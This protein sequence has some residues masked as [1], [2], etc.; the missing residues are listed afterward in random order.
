MREP[1]NNG[2]NRTSILCDMTAA[3]SSLICVLGK[4]GTSLW[5]PDDHGKLR[6]MSRPKKMKTAIWIG[7]KQW[8]S[9]KALADRLDRTA[10]QLVREAFDLLIKKYGAK[11][12]YRCH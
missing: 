5:Q 1:R 8:A 6:T 10:A 11:L 2:S 9:L 4:V 7:E 3:V 12:I